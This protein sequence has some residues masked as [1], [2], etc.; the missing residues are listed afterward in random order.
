LTI[1]RPLTRLFLVAA[2]YVAASWLVYGWTLDAPFLLDDQEAIRN[3]PAIHSLALPDVL[4]PPPTA[5]GFSRRP[6]ANLSMALNFAA[7]DLQ[8][9]GYRVFNL[10]LHAI[11]AFLLFCLVRLV[12][13]NFVRLS[14]R[15]AAVAACFAGLLWVVHPLSTSAVHYLTQRPEMLAACAFLAMFYAQSRSLL[16]SHPRR[17]LIAA[18]FACLLAMG[19]K[20]S[21]ALLPVLSVLFDRCV[22]GWTWREQWRR[23]GFY[24]AALAVTFVWPL[25]LLVKDDSG[26]VLHTG[27]EERWRYFLTVTE[28][29]ARH[30]FLVFWP[31][32][33]VF[34]YGTRFVEELGDTALHFFALVLSAMLILWGLWRRSLAA[35]AGAAVFAVM[36]PSWI[37]MAPGQPVAEHRFYLP[38]ALI[39]SVSAVAA[40]AWCTRNPR[41][42]VLVA[43]AVTFLSLVFAWLA[44]QRA[45]LYADPEALIS[46]DIKSWPRSDRSYMNLGLVLE[47][48]ED[49][50]GAARQYELAMASRESANWRPIVALARLK[51]RAGDVDG[52]V[53]LGAD[54]FRRVFS[55]PGSPDL[56]QLVNNVVSSFRSAGRLDA[57]LPLLNAAASTGEHSRLVGETI[58]I[59]SAE[60][61]GLP[62]IN[63]EFRKAAESN[64]LTRV[65]FAIALAREGKTGEAV[66]LL[67]RMI[68]EAPEGSDPLKIADVH[69]L[70]GAMS[71]DD[72]FAARASFKEAIRLNPSHS[73]ALNNFAWLLATSKDKAI[74][75][76]LQGLELA[77]KAVRLRPD[78]TN[79]Q[80][81]LAVALAAVGFEKE[82]EVA[83]SEAQRLGRI[84]GNSNPELPDLVRQARARAAKSR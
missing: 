2:V 77:R 11:N 4:N 37:N 34:D 7:G 1:V 36:L 50:E 29:L 61:K 35:W 44:V 70:K 64:P 75:D 28:G 45:A 58:R 42:R 33:L 30:V 65:N 48:E 53:A 17:W 47:V 43:V 60:T 20:E 18:W 51:M 52:A 10:L 16:S 8:I 71:A 24:Y 80:G 38:V 26:L 81:T 3:N 68:A 9:A 13:Q 25:L 54:A 19:S 63:E 83:L 66:A 41:W 12:A 73:E 46:R 72:P 39:L 56:P 67:D 84:N 82:V 31:R 22:A 78:E 55:V 32:A 49:Y 15:A 62:E 74:Y 5:M 76:P 57:A 79:F 6:V 59:V 69:A 40:F 27:L 14:A 21:M 23:R